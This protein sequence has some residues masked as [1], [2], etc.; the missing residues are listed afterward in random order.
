MALVTINNQSEIADRYQ[1]FLFL[2]HQNSTRCQ[3][4]SESSILLHTFYSQP[5]NE[6]FPRSY[7]KQKLDVLNFSRYTAGDKCS[8]VTLLVEY[9]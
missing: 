9:S 2:A 5:S 3:K 1:L 4:T 8:R 6:D 7:R